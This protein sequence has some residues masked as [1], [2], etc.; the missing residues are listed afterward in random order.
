MYDFDTVY[1]RKRSNSVK[2]AFH[3]DHGYSE[4]VIPMWVADMD[5]KSPPAVAE[6]VRKAAEHGF[7]GYGDDK[8]GWV[9][10]TIGCPRSIVQEALERIEKAI[11]K[12]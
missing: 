3:G 9:R 4:D 10:M 6:H 7:F 8:E 5:F 1:D 11:H 2:H 12:A